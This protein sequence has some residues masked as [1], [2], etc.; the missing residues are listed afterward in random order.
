MLR[1]HVKKALTVLVID[2]EPSVRS[3]VSLILGKASMR[4]LQADSAAAGRKLWDENRDAIDLLLVDISMPQISGPELV[5]ELARDGASL[6][7]IFMT[8]L[9]RGDA[10]EATIGLPHFSILQKPFAPQD[11][12]NAIDN[13]CAMPVV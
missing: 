5:Y 9:G 8:G 10:L 1:M 4:V 7:V 3:A 13:H 6:P 2:D 11:L 12:L